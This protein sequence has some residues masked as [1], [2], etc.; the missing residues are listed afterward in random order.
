MK[1]FRRNSFYGVATEVS[2]TG[3]ITVSPYLPYR[4]FKRVS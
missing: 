4:I 3:Q 1:I 2:Y